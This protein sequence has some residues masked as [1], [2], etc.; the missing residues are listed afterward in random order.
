ML[1]VLRAVLILA[2]LVLSACGEQPP[3]TSEPL[4]T[5][6]DS[7][8]AQPPVPGLPFDDPRLAPV[9]A[10]LRANPEWLHEQLA[11]E[12][13]VLA[14]V[15]GTTEVC[16]ALEGSTGEAFVTIDPSA[17]WRVLAVGIQRGDGTREYT[18]GPDDRSDVCTFIVIGRTEAW[19]AD[20]GAVEVSGNVDGNGA[21]AIAQAIHARPERFG[22]DRRG[23]PAV[24]VGDALTPAPPG[25]TCLEA[26]VFVGGPRSDVVIGIRPA[27]NGRWDIESRVVRRALHTPE[28]PQDGSC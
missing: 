14:L 4:P 9:F 22:I 11:E 5:E 6:D 27:E 13:D 23:V 3:L 16:L 8:V 12:P 21:R 10:Q 24:L 19:A 7:F 2:G 28:P 25:W 1:L 18:F 26:V 15:P 20:V 17:V